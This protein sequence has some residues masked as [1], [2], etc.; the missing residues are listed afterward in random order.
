MAAVQMGASERTLRHWENG[1]SPQAASYPGIIAFLDKEPWPEPATLPQ[2]LRAARWRRGLTIVQAAA[3]LGVDA[4]TVWWWETGRKPH[5]REHQVRITE[6]LASASFEEASATAID[7][8][9]GVSR[10]PMDLGAMLR[11][12]RRELGLSLEA[13]AALIGADVW[14]LMH[15]EHGRHAPT[16]RFYPSLIRFLGR[17]PWPE[18][19]TLAE[20]IKAERLRRGLSCKQAAAVI[21]VSP[22]SISAWE[23]GR[24][25]RH[26]IA[27]A[28]VEAF[29]TG[30]VRP[31]RTVRK[32]P[33]RLG[34]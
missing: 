25:P 22:D 32:R 13:A 2:Q 9:E 20:R 29:L 4:S 16:D 17:E 10:S 5:R 27:K 14:T 7:A 24:G 33:H 34:P 12:R 28:K 8:C 19:H 6:F 15:W 23:A 11:V 30:S 21:Q 26:G 18:P 3:V 1:H 31:M